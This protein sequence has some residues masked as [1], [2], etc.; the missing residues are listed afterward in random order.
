MTKTIFA[1]SLIC[2]SGSVTIPSITKAAAHEGIVGNGEIGYSGN[3][4]VKYVKLSPLE[5]VN[6]GE[7]VVTTEIESTEI[8][9]WESCHATFSSPQ[10]DFLKIPADNCKLSQLDE[11]NYLLEFTKRFGE[12]TVNRT[13]NLEYLS[14]FGEKTEFPVQ[15]GPVPALTVRSSAIINDVDR[16]VAEVTS[17]VLT[18]METKAT[19][20]LGLDSGF[21][22][23]DGMVE[24][25]VVPKHHPQET[26]WEHIFWSGSRWTSHR[27]VQS[28][29]IRPGLDS[30]T[31]VLPYE[32]SSIE[33]VIAEF[34]NEALQAAR[35]DRQMACKSSN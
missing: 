21:A 24:L 13:L 2:A 17:L 9:H 23:L 3:L 19:L 12:K 35:C 32:V 1:L 16:P 11:H 29:P 14:L 28:K 22:L 7:V 34:S 27:Q 4:I 25:K 15:P 20:A 33:V 10:N 8:F 26:R 30:V 18:P 5:I 6:G 31:L